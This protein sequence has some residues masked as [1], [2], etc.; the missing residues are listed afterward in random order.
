PGGGASSSAAP[1]RPDASPDTPRGAATAERGEHRTEDLPGALTGQRLDWSRCPAPSAAQGEDAG[2]PSPLEDGTEWECA[3]LTV[4]V[5]YAAPRG[6]TLGVAVVRAREREG[7]GG[8]GRIGSLLFNFGGPGGSGVAALPAFARDYRALHQRY[9]LV[10]FD[11]RGVGRS[12]GVVCLDGEQLD[13]YFA[14]DWTPDTAAE[15]KRLFRRQDRFAQACERRAGRLLPHLTTENTARDMD[16]LR[17]VLGDDKLHYFGISYGSELGGVYAH[18]FP[19]RVGRAVLDAVADPGATPAEGSLGQTA[20]FEKAL[21]SYLKDCARQDG[22]CPV[23]ADPAEA[24]REITELLARLDAEPLPTGGPRKLT[25][26]LAESGIAQ[27][28]YSER[29]WDALSQGL[30]EALRDGSGSTLLLLA[31]SLNGRNQ[32]GGYS[33]LQTSLTAINCADT[34]KRYTAQDIKA[35][36]PAF[37]RA[38]GV[39]GPASAWGLAHCRNWPATGRRT[40]PDVSAPGAPP[41]VLV[42]NTGDPATPYEGARRMARALGGSARLLTYKGEGHGSYD[43][44]DSCV[45]KAVDGYLLDG[46][47]PKDGTV[48]P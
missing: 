33:T 45:R 32:D 34:A 41:I 9:D 10:S 12:E 43:T 16:L 7:G 25:E 13:R 8:G 20:G 44:G 2:S 3:T 29:L 26:A 39:F 36:L 5:D 47:A 15:E 23:S 37:T 31:D 35:R 27:A 28:L 18:L 4:P 21:D 42:G 46:R 48:C 30:D 38:S 40:A 14:A 6:A 17:A 11:P 24:K 19:R 1:S 22:Q